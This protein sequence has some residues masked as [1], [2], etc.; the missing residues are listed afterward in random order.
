MLARIGIERLAAVLALLCT[1]TPAS[2]SV[3]T[4]L[5]SVD[6]IDAIFP[7]GGGSYTKSL[8]GGPDEGW[9]VFAANAG[10]TITVTLS[11]T[12]GTSM[13]AAA[14]DGAVLRDTD[15][16]VNV[17]DFVNIVD[18]SMDLTGMGSNLVVAHQ[19]FNPMPGPM[20]S[21]Q[22]T[23]AMSQSFMVTLLSA[24]Q[25]AVGVSCG[26]EICVNGSTFTVQVSGNTASLP[27]PEPAP[28]ALLGFGLAAI[29]FTRRR[30][31]P[32]RRDRP[33]S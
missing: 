31:G 8:T 26:D 30:K 10:D 21:Y 20:A 29:G 1:A 7:S 24:G 2:A 5:G 17:G 19:G 28:L 22:F 25:Y 18:F 15:G 16:V 6:F 9:S 4:M 32:R 3:L 33:R 23:S 11:A 14:Y 12:T 13:A 27:V